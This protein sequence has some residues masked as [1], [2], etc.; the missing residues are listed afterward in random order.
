MGGF[1]G[2]DR[3]RQLVDRLATMGY[4][5]L[6]PNLFGDKQAGSLDDVEWVKS[7]TDWN[8][9]RTSW[10]DSLL[11][12]IRDTLAVRTIGV[13]GTGWGAY[14]ACRLASYGEVNAGVLVNPSVSI[15]VEAKQ[16]DLYELFEEIECPQLFIT[17]RDDCPNEKQDGLACKIFKSCVFGK[18]CEFV[19]LKDMT[20]GFLLSGDRSVEAVAVQAKNTMN[21]AVKFFNKHLHY[22]GEVIPVPEETAKKTNRNNFDLSCHTSDACRVCLEVRH[23]AEKSA[24]RN[25]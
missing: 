18:Q 23:Q 4:I 7:V 19:E 3:T 5:V 6:L 14:T 1:N 15:V 11:P 2:D 21:M 24:I 10:I 16:E 13:V 12:W 9:F 25:L 17:S 20:H 22:P 8:N